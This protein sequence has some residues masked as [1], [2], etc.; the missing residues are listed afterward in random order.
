LEEVIDQSNPFTCKSKGLTKF[1]N[2]FG[3]VIDQSNYQTTLHVS[4]WKSIS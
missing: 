1:C 2:F 4:P 3:K